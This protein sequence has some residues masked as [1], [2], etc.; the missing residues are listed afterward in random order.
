MTC[1]SW[2]ST[3]SPTRPLAHPLAFDST[4][5]RLNA[6]DNELTVA[7][8]RAQGRRPCLG[9]YLTD[10]PAPFQQIGTEQAIG[11]LVDVHRPMARPLCG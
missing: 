6:A 1:R 10:R 2:P 11:R 3:T 9:G 8:G 7:G 5:G 4:Y